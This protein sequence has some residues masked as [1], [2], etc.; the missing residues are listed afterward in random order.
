MSAELSSKNHQKIK[1]GY[2]LFLPVCCNILT[3]ID[4]VDTRLQLERKF[5]YLRKFSDLIKSEKGKLDGNDQDK[6]I[7][8]KQD[9][10]QPHIFT[11]NIV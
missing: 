2:S 5:P 10:L 3:D 7:R 6:K 1:T 11:K 9:N 4:L 8:R